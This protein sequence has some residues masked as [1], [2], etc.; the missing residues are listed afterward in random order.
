MT[1]RILIFRPGS[2]GDTIVAL[3]CLKLIRKTFPDAELRVLTNAPIAS[4]APPLAAI[5]EG[6]G[7]VSSYLE[8]P[9]ATR[10]PTKLLRLAQDIWR[11]RPDVLVYLARRETSGQVRRDAAFFRACGIRRIVGLPAEPDLLKNRR[12]PD[13]SFEREAER[14]ARNMVSLGTI[15]FANPAAFDLGLGEADRALPR[16]LIA[17]RIGGQPF[18]AVSIGT[19]QLA[20]DWGVQNWHELCAQLC[21]LYP[22]R[23]V[24]TGGREDDARSDAVIEGLRERAVNLCG[25]KVRE[26][27]ALIEA[28]SLFIGHDSGPMHMAAA[29]GTP[30]IAVFSR[31]WVPGI[32]YPMGGAPATLLYPTGDSIRSVTPGMV[33]D[34]VRAL[35]PAVVPVRKLVGEP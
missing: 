3:P 8:Y 28:A 1:G 9:I 13:G 24:L 29:V 32:W 20:N 10:S 4:S 22:H 18:I 7:L 33:V 11:W 34:A 26:N 31:L 2:L 17:E 14:L 23:L 21:G 27:A 25:L 15:E 35:L 16:R 12:R 30:L 5:L 19:K 6:M